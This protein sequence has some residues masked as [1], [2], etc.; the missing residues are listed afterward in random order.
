MKS[1]VLNAATQ[2]AVFSGIVPASA[3]AVS[4]GNNKGPCVSSYPTNGYPTNGT[5]NGTTTAPPTPTATEPCVVA[6]DAFTSQASASP[7]VVPTMA[8]S[9][10]YEC[11]KSVPVHKEPAIRLLDELKPFLEWQSDQAFLKNPPSDYPYPP[12]DIFGELETIRSNLQA[13]K[14]SGE[15]EWQEDLYSTITGKPHNGHLAYHPDLLTVPFEWVRPWTLVSVSED[16]TSLPMIRVLEDAMSPHEKS[17]H[18]VKINGV[19]AASYIERRVTD[20][21]NTQDPDAGYNTMFF[22]QAN[23]AGLQANGYFEGGGRE[24]FFYPGNTTSLTFANGTT[25]EKPNIAR[26]HYG[27]YDWNNVMD[28]ETMHK[29]FCRGAYTAES[30]RIAT[31][32]VK[33]TRS[34]VSPNGVNNYPQPPK[35]RVSRQDEPNKIAGYPEPVVITY[36]QIVSGYFIDEPGFE[37]I[38]VL[39]MLSFSSDFVSFQSAVQDFFTKAVEAGKTKLI[40]DLQANGGGTILQGYDTFRQLFP[41]IVQDGPTRWRSSPSFNALSETISPLC[42]NYTPKLD[43]QN[44]DNAC[45]TVNNWRND[46]NDTNGRFTSYADKFGPLTAAD[47]DSYT[48]YMEWDPA[49]PVLTRQAFGTDI[50]G[51]G[52]RANFTRPFGGAENIVLLYDG[53][54]ASTCSIFAQFMKH[55]AGVKSVAMGGRP[56]HKGPIQGVGG[57]KGAQ[58]YPFR[59][60][61]ILADLARSYTTSPALTTELRRLDDVYVSGRSPYQVPVVNVR[62]AVLPGALDAGVP[63][64]FVTELADCRLYWTRPMI[65]NTAEIW[66]AAARAAFRGDKCV[67]GGIAP[68]ARRPQFTAAASAPL[69][70]YKKRPLPVRAGQVLAPDSLVMQQMRVQVS[71]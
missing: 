54:C 59:Q 48:N 60:M 46:L 52:R 39:A 8:A 2:I 47:G 51:Y 53:Y 24:R 5:T 45:T 55:G 29:E 25:I 11:L 28:A 31:R 67:A 63:T 9:L 43:Y 6:R 30:S 69:R 16:G 20:S 62:D 33:S 66:K 19:D 64:Q 58:V 12:V 61:G 1:L 34:R 14:Y 26:F 44:L 36:D 42:A 13:D 3:S 50:T 41:D 10:A 21:S 70:A 27:P 40:V 49:N 68:P 4:H 57:V 18:V 32:N 35:L 22:S 7:G 15:L 23:K 65:R 71:D 17:P 56:H 38:A 37:D